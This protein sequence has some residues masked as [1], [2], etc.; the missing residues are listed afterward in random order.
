[1]G[2][3]WCDLYNAH[4]IHPLISSAHEVSVGPLQRELARIKPQD[5]PYSTR[6]LLHVRKNLERWVD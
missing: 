3:V 4:H 6:E 5:T 1:M 2:G